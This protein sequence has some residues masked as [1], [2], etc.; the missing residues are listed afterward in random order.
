MK[1]VVLWLCLLS[2]AGSSSGAAEFKCAEPP[3]AMKFSLTSYRNKT[4]HWKAQV[5][6]EHRA[7]EQDSA[8]WEVDIDH[9]V[10]PQYNGSDTILIVAT[11]T[12][13]PVGTAV[14]TPEAPKP[15]PEG[16]RKFSESD[17]FK[18]YA[19]ENSWVPAR[20]ICQKEGAHL[21]VVN[22]EAEAR[23]ITSLWN[24]K[25]DWAFIGTH[26]LYEEGIYVTIYN[27]SLSAAGYDKWFLGE[28]NGGTAENCGV[29]NR[30]TLLG[31]YFCNRHLPFIC[32]FQN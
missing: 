17:Y 19:A 29:I 28:P 2:A 1:T 5:Q 10:T 24:S 9:R 4:G 22:S 21:A 18:V 8:E 26:D 15:V 23:F 3:S 31:N 25:S 20:D 14:V 32:E 7:T 13:P 27:Q 12:V 16:Y 30:N 11:V 6:L